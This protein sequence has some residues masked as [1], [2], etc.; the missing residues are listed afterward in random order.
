MADSVQSHVC[1]SRPLPEAPGGRAESAC[2]ALSLGLQVPGGSGSLDRWEGQQ[3]P[4]AGDPPPLQ[5]APQ[6]GQQT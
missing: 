2:S 3:V 4:G 6:Q 1:G 5:P